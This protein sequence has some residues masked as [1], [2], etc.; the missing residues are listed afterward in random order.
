MLADDIRKLAEENI[1]KHIQE[2]NIIS[3]KQL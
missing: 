1:L 2:Y 3:N